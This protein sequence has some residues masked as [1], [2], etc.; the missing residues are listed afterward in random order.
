M[1]TQKKPE[2][3]QKLSGTGYLNITP[4]QQRVI[5]AALKGAE[6]A[7]SESMQAHL[8]SGIPFNEAHQALVKSV[9][10]QAIPEQDVSNMINQLMQL[11]QQTYD[12][13]T[14]DTAG[15]LGPLFGYKPGQAIT[16]PESIGLTNAISLTKFPGEMKQ[17]EN[18]LQKA[19]YE[20]QQLRGQLEQQP[21]QKKKLEQETNPVFQDRKLKRE[22]SI[23]SGFK[24]KE[25]DRK[26]E[27][28]FMSNILQ[29]KPMAGESAQKYNFT[30]EA[31]DA[32]QQLLELLESNPKTLRELDIIG[33]NK[34]QRVGTITARLRASLVPA[35]AGATQSAQEIKLIDKMSSKSGMQALLKDPDDLKFR[36]QE[37]NRSM[38]RQA[39]SL[40]PTEEDR[41]LAKHL[42][43]KG[44]SK[45][46]VYKFLIER[47]SK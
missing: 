31:K 20:L 43:S 2:G 21:L 40:N 17:Q 22:E 4:E 15:M 24:I 26:M 30:L 3:S 25:E 39:K 29:Q 5:D 37:I 12:K 11:S 41:G 47:E 8:A 46:E 33:N 35:R 18:S 38:S 7:A 13:P 14:G 1:D 32:S 10:P 34:G 9:A 27:N 36:L 6:K 19:P 44:Y 42:L 45:S 23:K 28:E 16:K